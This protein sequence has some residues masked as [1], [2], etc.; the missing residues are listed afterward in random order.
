MKLNELHIGA[1]AKVIEVG[2][3]GSLRRHFLDMGI[4]PGE[5]VKLLKFAPMGDPMEILIHGYSLSLRKSEASKIKIEP[6][7]DSPEVEET[8]NYSENTEHPG[9]GETGKFHDRSHENPLPKGTTLSFAIAGNDNSGRTTLFNQLTGT[10]QHPGVSAEIKAGQIKGHPDTVVMNLPGFYS[11]SP[12]TAEEIVSRNY[13]L[14]E[15]PKG[16]INIVDANNIERNLYLTTQLMELDIPMV[17]AVNVI[18]ELRNNGGTILINEME[19]ILG[20]PVVPISASSNEGVHELVDHAIHVAKYQEK[21]EKYDI[22]GKDEFGGAVHRCIHSIVHLIEDHAERAGIP[23]RFAAV[24]LI[25]GDKSIEKILSLERNEKQMIEHII[26]QMETERGLDRAAA[27]A[28][29]RYNFIRKLCAKTVIK[30]KESK[31]HIRSN[32]IDKILTGKWT[33][34]PIF[35][36]VMFLVIWLSIDVLGSPLQNLLNR[37]IEHLSLRTD[38]AMASV[39]V[40][41]AVRSLVVHGIFGGV[42]SVLSFVPIIIILFFFL[43][44]LR[45]SGY[46]ARIAF[47]SDKL[48]RKLGLSGR[49][50]VPLLV[51]FGCSVPAVMATRTLPSARDRRRTILLMPFISCSAKIPIYAFFTTT[52]FPD[53]GG[54]V[55]ASVYLFAI[56]V[57]I[58]VALVMKFIKR[59]DTPTP[60][61]MELP[62]YRLPALA[63]VAHIIWDETK[64][65]LQRA[66]TII[67][68]AS[69]AIWFLRSFNFRLDFVSDGSGS[70]L[71]AIA[72]FIAPLFTPVGLGDWGIVTALIS[73]FVAK[74]SVVATI[75]VLGLAASMTLTTAI[76]MLVF[77][78]IYTP[79]VAAIAAVKRELGRKW[80]LYMILVQCVLAWLLAGAAYVIVRMIV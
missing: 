24:K 64:D 62:T 36:A 16:I 55:L 43:S 14:E 31:E 72:G 63:N 79:C 68:L 5:I 74:E 70:I 9:L 15:K 76:P 46:M 73:G 53:Y 75:E 44:I 2:G 17:L 45:D 7:E 3:D 52:F 26:V 78:I 56:L 32:K 47:V 41:D 22:C 71:A 28:D 67:F 29:M 1:S 20:I 11:L 61:V 35:I 50:I 60:F 19:S 59:K 77:C 40:G 49:S 51:G 27:I 65:F 57:G 38:A 12:Y 18:D 23:V 34:I 33:A 21:P 69:V 13:L 80:A 48:L 30:P 4:I 39:G 42:G 10:K 58:L 25:E 37:G 54:L 8:I 66:F 6:I